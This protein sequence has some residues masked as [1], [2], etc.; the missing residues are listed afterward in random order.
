M[1]TTN[2]N[3][4]MN[5]MIDELLNYHRDGSPITSMDLLMECVRRSVED[6]TPQELNEIASLHRLLSKIAKTPK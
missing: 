5:E 3:A 4:Q 6:L 1:S 2:T